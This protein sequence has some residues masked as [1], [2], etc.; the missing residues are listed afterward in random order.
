[1]N[2]VLFIIATITTLGLFWAGAYAIKASIVYV[3]TSIL[4]VLTFMFSTNKSESP[5]QAEASD[6][7]SESVI[8]EEHLVLPSVAANEELVVALPVNEV[9]WSV[10]DVPTYLRR[11]IAIQVC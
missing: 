9:D 4:K 2:F 5:A 10:Y 3:A 1:M 7:P 8:E 6:E 11:G